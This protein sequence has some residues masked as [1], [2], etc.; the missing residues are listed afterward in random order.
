MVRTGILA[1]FLILR[2]S[3]QLFT[4]DMTLAVLLSYAT[5]IMLSYGPSICT[6]WRC[7]LKNVYIINGY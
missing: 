3:F 7:F 6:L 5:F 1:L 4:T 2:E